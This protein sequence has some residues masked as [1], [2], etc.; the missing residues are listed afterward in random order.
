MGITQFKIIVTLY[1]IL[2]P[3][4]GYGKPPLAMAAGGQKQGRF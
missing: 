4:Y 1:K 3:G 2:R